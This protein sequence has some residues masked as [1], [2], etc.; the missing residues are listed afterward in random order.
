MPKIPIT[1]NVLGENLNVFSTTSRAWPW[2][3]TNWFGLTEV[4]SLPAIFFFFFF[5]LLRKACECFN[6]GKGE[7]VCGL[8]PTLQGVSLGFLYKP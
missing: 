2:S 7:R 4:G 5:F 8:T 6:A 1:P 3:S